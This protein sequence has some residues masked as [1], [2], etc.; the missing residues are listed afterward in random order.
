MAQTV[1]LKLTIQGN[2][3]QGESTI[4]SLERADTIECSSFS[5][6][7]MTPYD[8]TTMALTGKALR[9]PVKI[10]KGID[11]TTPLLLKAL[12]QQE[13]VDSAEFRFYREDP[14]GSG[15]K[16]GSHR[17]ARH[18]C[19]A[20]LIGPFQ[21]ILFLRIIVCT[22]VLQTRKVSSARKTSRL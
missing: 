10:V 5:C 12:Y 1:H 7:L 18:S 17:E 22:P 16:G 21:K 2:D 6:G 11:K 20:V 13:P 14:G 3:I 9:E 4:A 8:K 19:C 15:E